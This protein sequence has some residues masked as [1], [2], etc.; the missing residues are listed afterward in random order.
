[1]Y[2]QKPRALLPLG[3][4]K[5]NDKGVRVIGRVYKPIK[6]SKKNSKAP[7]KSSKAKGWIYTIQVEQDFAVIGEDNLIAILKGI[8]SIDLLPQV[9][10]QKLFF[11]SQDLDFAPPFSEDVTNYFRRLPNR[12]TEYVGI[13]ASEPSP[14]R[15][16]HQWVYLVRH[17]G[18]LAVITDSNL[19]AF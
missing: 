16:T 1:M 5:G 13:A 7:K 12:R 15:K 17:M 14:N 6:D 10:Y 4:Q 11:S 18:N 19:N 8:V 3:T 2:T 9:A